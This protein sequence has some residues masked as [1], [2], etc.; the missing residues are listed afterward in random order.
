[1]TTSNKTK[2]QVFEFINED[3][4]EGRGDLMLPGLHLSA[5]IKRYLD[6]GENKLHCHP[7]EDHTFYILQGAA[8]FRIDSDDNIVHAGKFEAVYLPA[9]T[10]V[11]VPQLRRRKADHAARWH[12]AG[13]RPDHR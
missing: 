7:D 12:G 8:D 3:I 1:M 4:L 6:G 9:G 2:A 13:V 5:C 11:L 10:N